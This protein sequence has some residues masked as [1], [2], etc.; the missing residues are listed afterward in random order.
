MY[1]TIIIGAGPAGM[2]AG[3]Y[4][5]RKKM[6][7]LII[8]Q[9]VGGQ[10]AKTA[11]IENHPGEKITDGVGLAFKI[12]KQAEDFGVEFVTSKVKAIKKQADNLFEIE[13]EDNK[14]FQTKSIILAFGMEKRKLGLENEKNFMNK[15]IS[16][17]VTCDG[18]LFKNKK[19]AVVGGGNAGAEAVEFL[20]KSCP[21]VYWLEMMP[22]LNADKIL[23]NRIA[24]LENVKTMTDT[25]ITDFIGDDKLEKI[26]LRQAQGT[27]DK[28]EV[29][30]LEVS[31]VFVEIGYISHS[32]WLKDLIDLDKMG[33]IKVNELCQTN[34]PGIFAV[35]DCTQTK[36]K[37]IVIA[38]GMGAIAGLEAYEFI[39]K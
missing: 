7:T 23:Q 28:S 36:Y 27:S 8:S 39:N 14:K 13:T 10:M 4:T 31:G 33:Q 11:I 25:Q 19:V 38:E 3:I 34:V 17:C 9:D 32:E 24:K 15:G 20:A 26:T 6:K 16:Y 30:S 12:K 5:A 35:G 22:K 2:T 29:K 1:D 21:K 18:P 37:Q